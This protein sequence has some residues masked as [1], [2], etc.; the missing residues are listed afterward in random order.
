MENIMANLDVWTDEEL[1]EK[2]E[3]VFE[4]IGLDMETAV[5]LFLEQAVKENKLPFTSEIP[6]MIS[7]EEIAAK[8][9]SAFGIWKGK[10]EWPEDFDKPLEDF[11]NY[12]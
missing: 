8:R 7:K 11:K 3:K 1:E 12:M 4:S 2:A 9:R 6:H 5:K 10:Y